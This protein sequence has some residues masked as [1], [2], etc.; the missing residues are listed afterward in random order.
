[1]K[2]Q[3]FLLPWLVFCFVSCRNEGQGKHEN[4]ELVTKSARSIFKNKNMDIVELRDG[5]SIKYKTLTKDEY[6]ALL[7]DTIGE[8]LAKPYEIEAHRLKDK[9]VLAKSKEYY[10]LYFSMYDLDRIITDFSD[11][12]SQG[13]EVLMNKNKYGDA[14]PINTNMMI[15]ALLDSLHIEYK[16]P[17]VEL[18]LEIDKEIDKL[19][20]PDIFMKEHFM[21]IV[22]VVGE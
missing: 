2:N 15:K 22:A 17:S 12:G 1:M 20:Y 4:I 19:E 10:A 3:F 6:N 14:F 7:K 9:R 5:T 13:N 21:D 16:K 8:A 18:L 11:G